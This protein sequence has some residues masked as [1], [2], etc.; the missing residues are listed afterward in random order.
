MVILLRIT[1][2]NLRPKYMNIGEL[3]NKIT[4]AILHLYFKKLLGGLK[5]IAVIIALISMVVII[6]GAIFSLVPQF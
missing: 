5:P 4:D 1:D 2:S 6:I 3:L